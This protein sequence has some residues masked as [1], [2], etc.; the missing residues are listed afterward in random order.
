MKLIF[1]NWNKFL[2]EAHGLSKEDAMALEQ[3][4][5]TVT[6]QNIKRIL[7]F[8]ISSNVEVDRTQDVTKMNKKAN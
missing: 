1:E 5:N 7:S 4:A 8:V 2:N 3:F 6:D